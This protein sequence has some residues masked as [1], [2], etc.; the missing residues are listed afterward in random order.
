MITFSRSPSTDSFAES[1]ACLAAK[2][3]CSLGKIL[4][5]AG[6]IFLLGGGIALAGFGPHFLPHVL[7]TTAA[8][9]T[10]GATLGGLAFASFGA[11]CWVNRKKETWVEN[12]G[13]AETINEAYNFTEE[14]SKTFFC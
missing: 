13:L 10:E 1:A 3:R 2:R 9:I 12:A 5:I 4:L 6:G 11:F 8:R 14:E 7:S